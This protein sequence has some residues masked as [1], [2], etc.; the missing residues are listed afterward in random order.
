VGDLDLEPFV[1]EGGG[2]KVGDA[3]LVVHDE[4]PDVLGRRL[5]SH[6]PNRRPTSWEKPESSLWI[7]CQPDMRIAWIRSDFPIFER[8]GIDFRFAIS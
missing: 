3:L 7:C 5:L 4:D 8:P 6:G 2:Q 1:S